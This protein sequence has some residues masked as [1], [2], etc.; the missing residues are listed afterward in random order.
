VKWQPVPITIREA[1]PLLR[2]WHRRRKTCHAARFALA[3]A[4]DGTIRGVAFCGNP[5][6]TKAKRIQNGGA[7]EVLRLAVD[8]SPNACTRLQAV[9]DRTARAMGYTSLVTFTD[10]DEGGASLRAAGW[11][12]PELTRGGTRSNRKNRKSGKQEPKW[13]WTRNVGSPQ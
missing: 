2:L 7:L 6:A 3:L 5:V 12:G 9:I 1:R 8:G 10:I 13:R 11:T 4:G